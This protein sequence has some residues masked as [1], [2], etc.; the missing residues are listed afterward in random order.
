MRSKV[1][2]SMSRILDM[3]IPY[4]LEHYGLVTLKLSSFSSIQRKRILARVDY[5]VEIGDVKP[6]ELESVINN[7][8]IKFNVTT[9]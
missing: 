2:P 4:L 7:L 5:L 9:D 3:P 1:T 8:K 6:E